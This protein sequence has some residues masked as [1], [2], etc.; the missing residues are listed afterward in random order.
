MAG[1]HPGEQ[2]GS[3]P[4]QLSC[5]ISTWVGVVVL[6]VQDRVRDPTRNINPIIATMRLCMAFSFGAPLAFRR[7]GWLSP[8]A[9]GQGSKP[10]RG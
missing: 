8:A 5:R 2:A 1:G 6:S 4:H 3:I 7:P 9:M 10:V